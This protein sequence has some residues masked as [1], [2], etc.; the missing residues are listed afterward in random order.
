MAGSFMFDFDTDKMS[1]CLKVPSEKFRD[2]LKSGLDDYMTT[3]VKELDT[4]PSRD[5]LL[6]RFYAHC[7]DCLDVELEAAQPTDNE[8]AA[9]AVQEDK[10]QDPEWTY[11]K[12][13][14]FVQMGVRISGDTLLTEA[15]HKAPGGMIRARLLAKDGRIDDLMITGDFT[16]LPESGVETLS[17]SLQG[18]DLKQGTLAARIESIVKECGLEMPGVD[19]DDIETAILAA[20]HKD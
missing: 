17:Q 8:L 16:C 14:K 5:D 15:A 11:R 4:P 6:A 12:G 9:I 7:G 1:K 19:A 13:R 10:L 3:I 2:K 18:E 20:V